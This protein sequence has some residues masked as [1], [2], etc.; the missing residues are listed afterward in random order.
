MAKK[1]EHRDAVLYIADKLKEE[2]ERCPDIIL[3]SSIEVFI[4][5]ILIF[6]EDFLIENG[7]IRKDQLYD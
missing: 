7:V 6:Y 3:S 1:F 5:L 2:L 4:K